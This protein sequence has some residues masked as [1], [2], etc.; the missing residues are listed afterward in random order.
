MI[1]WLRGTARLCCVL[2]WLLLGLFFVT[3]I[4]PVMGP[5][6]RGAMVRHW[7]RLLMRGFG[8]AVIP[9]GEAVLSGPVLTVANHVSWIDVFVLN[10]VRAT[11]FIA[12]HEIRRWPVIGW[13]V[14][15]A[16]AVFIKRGQRHAVREVGEDMRRRFEQGEAVGLFPESTTSEGRELLP[17]HAS[18]F[19]P[20]CDHAAVV[21]QPVAL[22]F[23]RHGKRSDYAAFVGEESLAVN[24]WRVLGASGLS[25]EAVYLPPL[26][27][28][29]AD[30][31]AHT[32]QSL[33]RAAYAVIA[34]ALD[35]CG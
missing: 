26:P 19:A 6:V 28:C 5:V 22:R 32:R 33:A 29:D 24:V 4:F 30:G 12:K 9:R 7:S 17:F 10:S 8:V 1:T 27:T 34:Q 23:L 2:V 15:G 25:V 18:L 11:C 21:V 3:V 35:E 13:L 16:G 31:Q 20:A 14:A